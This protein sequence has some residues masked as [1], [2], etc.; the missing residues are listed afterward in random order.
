MNSIP[1]LLSRLLR[2]FPVNHL[3]DKF[4]SEERLQDNIIGDILLKNNQQ[5]INDFVVDNIDFT[6]KSVHVYSIKNKY[7]HKQNISSND[8]GLEIL[9]QTSAN[10]VFS[11]IGYHKLKYD[12]IIY[13]QTGKKTVSIFFKQ[14]IKI[15]IDKFYLIIELTKVETNLK[16]YF[17]NDIDLVSSKRVIDDTHAIHAILTYFDSQFKIRPSKADINKGI[18]FLWKNDII[19]GKELAYRKTSSRTKEIMDGEELFKNKYPVEYKDIMKN[20]IE[21][22]IFRYLLENDDF[23]SHFTCDVSSGVLS[24]TIYPKAVNQISNVI[25]EIIKN[26]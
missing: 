9:S 21:S 1:L 18:K 13:D 17:T 12:A 25:N 16:A 3:K 7:Q 23:P 4:E 10:G 5:G 15:V 19:D 20:P 14:P 2:L 24:F 26:N 6:K 11:L 22:C 8:L